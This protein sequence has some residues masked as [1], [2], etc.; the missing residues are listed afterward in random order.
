MQE[1]FDF[2]GHYW[3][4]AFPLFGVMA[5]VGGAWERSARRRHK[6][7]LEVL[8]AK[9]E[10]KAAQ[11]AARGKTGPITTTPAPIPQRL[12][13]A[14]TPTQL[15]QLFSAHD[16]VTAR[17]LEYELDVAKLIAF[18]A[19]SD[20][21]QPLTAAFLRAKKVAD[22]LRPAAA[23]IKLTREQL[24]EYRNA[25]TDFEVAFDVAERDA[26]RIKDSGFTEIERKRLDTAK[27]LITVAI[28]EAATPAERQLAYRRVRQELDGL[29]SLSDEAIE[30]LENKVALELPAART[31][32]RASTLPPSAPAQPAPSAPQTWPVPSRSGDTPPGRVVRPKPQ[33]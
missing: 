31:E 2:I 17:W 28:D 26:R 33:S 12:G 20:G 5:S 24:A 23:N 1:V 7:R 10:L 3:W 32:P 4:L 14:P 15:Q 6:R 21:R 27:Q 11:A 22:R 30:V 18:P 16:A 19:M 29:I 25:V 9:A 13:T 8:H